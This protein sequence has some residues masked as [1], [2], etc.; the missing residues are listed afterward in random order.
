MSAIMYY[1]RVT[2]QKFKLTSLAAEAKNISLKLF[3]DFD[4][5]KK[6]VCILHAHI[7]VI[8]CLEH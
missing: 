1:F 5:Y 8:A 2:V 3:L 7:F 6:L 4:H